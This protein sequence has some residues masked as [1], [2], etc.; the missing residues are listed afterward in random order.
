ML[1][2][3]CK[4]I[5]LLRLSI[6]LVCGPPAESPEILKLCMHVYTV[7]LVGLLGC[8]LSLSAS[9]GVRLQGLRWE[10]SLTY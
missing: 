7:T 9:L 3:L 6:C 2:V 10:G 1:E 8:G 4:D 5:T